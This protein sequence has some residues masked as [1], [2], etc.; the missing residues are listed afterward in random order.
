M[1]V[2]QTGAEA[3]AEGERRLAMVGR[4]TRALEIRD[5]VLRLMERDGTWD[6]LE[7]SRCRK[8][9]NGRFM[10]LLNTAFN[11]L[12]HANPPPMTFRQ[13]VARQRAPEVCSNEL[14]VWAD[15]KVLLIEWNDQDARVITFKRGEWE[16]E[17]LSTS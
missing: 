15:K 16:T 10:A 9:K 3:R 7:G 17:L 12:P 11:P 13:A 5:H 2:L 6:R 1:P 4:D 8:W 14:S